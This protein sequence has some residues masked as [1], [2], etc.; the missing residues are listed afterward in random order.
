[1]GRV[2][3]KVAVITGATG[4]IGGA[5]ALRLAEEG[6]NVVLTW[7]RSRETAERTA[8][9]VRTFGVDAITAKVDN[10]DRGDI[11]RMVEAAIG[12]FGR[13]DIYVDC[14]GGIQPGRPASGIDGLPD[15]FF[16]D[17]VIDVNLKGPYWCAEAIVPHMQHQ[18]SGAIVFT[19]STSKDGIMQSDKYRGLANRVAYAASNA[20]IVGTMRVMA[21]YLAEHGIRVNCVVPGP[22]SDSVVGSVGRLTPLGRWGKTVEVANAILYLASDESS[23]VTGEALYVSGGFKGGGFNPSVVKLMV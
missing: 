15:E 17:H 3:G 7:N 19:S 22:I 5:T 16:Y 12:R 23:Y 21:N 14:S 10:L 11:R 20:G 18:G 8:E 9:T 13:I 4:K 1:M 6:A 2:E